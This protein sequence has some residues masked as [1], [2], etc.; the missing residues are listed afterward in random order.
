MADGIPGML[1]VPNGSDHIGG[2]LVHE[3]I[4]A[5]DPP[6]GGNK[7]A[8]YFGQGSHEMHTKAEDTYKYETYDLPEAYKGKN[9]FLRDTV[10][11]FIL[12]DNEWYTRVVL[13]YMQTDQIHLKWNEWHFNQTLAGRVPHEGISR[14]ITSSKRSF[15]DH[16]VRRG[17]AFILEHARRPTLTDDS[18]VFVVYF[19]TRLAVLKNFL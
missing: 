7:W 8:P 12:H 3:S 19:L 16:T 17:L 15:K 2:K 5:S 11:G 18:W 6:Q 14:L 4:T 9:L 10:E 13:P 1:N